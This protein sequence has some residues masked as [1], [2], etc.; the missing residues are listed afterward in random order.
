MTASRTPGSGLE[1]YGHRD[2]PRPHLTERKKSGPEGRG[3][4]VEVE[5]EG[6]TSHSSA[7]YS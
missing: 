3:R 5:D 2:G 4:V 6:G 1:T 7:I